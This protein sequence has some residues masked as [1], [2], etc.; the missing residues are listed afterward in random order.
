M[1]TLRGTAVSVGDMSFRMEPLTTSYLMKVLAR[2]SGAEGR[3]D[4]A[5][6]FARGNANRGWAVPSSLFQLAIASA[7]AFARSS[8]DDCA[9]FDCDRGGI[10]CS[11]STP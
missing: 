5:K 7:D 10:S 11:E 9:A 3:H 2:P 6:S 8:Y 4:C 1:A